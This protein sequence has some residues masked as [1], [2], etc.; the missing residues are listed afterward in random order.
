MYVAPWGGVPDD[1]LWSATGFTGAELSYGELLAGAS[2][3]AQR[4]IALRFLADRMAA[5]ASRAA[6]AP[7]RRAS[8]RPDRRLWRRWA[9]DYATSRTGSVFIW[10]RKPDST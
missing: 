3:A 1:D 9:V 6:P 2:G 7:T 10:L 4:E 8:R 5:L